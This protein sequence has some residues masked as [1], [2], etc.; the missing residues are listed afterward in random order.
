M[1]I[2]SVLSITTWLF[3]GASVVSCSTGVQT[4][5][6]SSNPSSAESLLQSQTPSAPPS[7]GAFY[8]GNYRNLVS[9]YGISAN[10][11]SRLNDTWN[12]F[13]NSTDNNKRL[14]YSAGR[15]NNGP[16]G[17]ILDTGNNDV[18]S[19][20]MSYGMMIAVQMNKQ[21]TFDS[22][23]NW[24]KTNMQ[25]SSG[26]NK[27]YFAWHCTTS[28]SKIDQNPAPD[29]EEYFA[30]A[31]EFAAGRWGSKT[32]IYDYQKEAN[33]I[34]N[35]M[36]HKEDMNGGVVGGVTNM[37]N[38]YNQV[39]FVP[40]TD[41]GVNSFTDPSYHVPAFYDLFSRWAWGYQ[42][43]DADRARWTN[44]ANSSRYYLFE[45]AADSITGLSPDYS[46]FN[47]VP[48][49]L[50][51]NDGHNNYAYDAWRTAMNWAVDYAWFAQGS[52]E[53]TL[54]DR[55]QGFM[56]GKGPS[57]INNT[58]TLNGTALDSYHDAGHV[59][60]LATSSLAASNPTRAA[61]FVDELWTKS[62]I[63]T[64]QYRYYSGMLYFMGLL[65][66][67]GNFK[68]YTPPTIK[69]APPF[70]FASYDGSKPALTS[71]QGGNL[72]QYAYSQNPNDGT[73]ANVV[74]SSTSIS[75]DYKLSKAAGSSYG[76]AVLVVD[77]KPDNDANGGTPAPATD[78]SGYSKIRLALS[79]SATGQVQIKLGG[80]D[81]SVQNSGCYPVALVNVT[82]ILKTYTL[83]LTAANFAPR[84]YC[85]GQTHKTLAQTLPVL[86]RI[87]V[88]DHDL[89]ASGDKNG[90]LTLGTVEFLK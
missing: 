89:P 33:D 28:G 60:M 59:A 88:E 2:K 45:H 29:G 4:P 15:N 32:R 77:G 66:T 61:A 87:E 85:L 86:T 73:V 56:Y 13:F 49:S 74:K 34:L 44:I 10:V 35:V 21:S 7:T 55:L 62:S 24:A 46:E 65:H 57:S 38:Q 83:D 8:S 84:D 79:A 54:T 6:T 48:K 40:S 68:I 72:Y 47:G 17:Y 43:K 5:N 1:K 11:P 50:N 39:V 9:E 69:E 64:G 36:L 3:V 70:I 12:Q 27:G 75:V 41:G 90:T 52:A 22:L 14:Y 42:D 81:V 53:T 23:W 78:V 20:G 71:I 18:R 76:G 58:Y 67:S 30:M 16:M 80:D 51:A 37:F 82:P 25:H 26:A 63:P 31:L 19:E